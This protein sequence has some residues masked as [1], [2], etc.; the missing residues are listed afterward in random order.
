MRILYTLAFTIGRSVA[1]G[2]NAAPAVVSAASNARAEIVAGYAAGRGSPASD[3]PKPQ[4]G[5]EF[6]V[7]SIKRTAAKVQARRAARGLV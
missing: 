7:E 4:D 6:S 2:H 5:P 1:A 3:A